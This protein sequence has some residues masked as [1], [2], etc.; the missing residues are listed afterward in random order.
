M[1]I[2][3]I[4]RLAPAGSMFIVRIGILITDTDHCIQVVEVF[5][6]AYRIV[7]T[8]VSNLCLGYPSD[9]VPQRTFSLHFGPKSRGARSYCFSGN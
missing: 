4:A 7:R 8:K 9:K 5:N 2:V 6:P 3:R 1:L